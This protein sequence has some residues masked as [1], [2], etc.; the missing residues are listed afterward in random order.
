MSNQSWSRVGVATSLLGV[1][2]AFVFWRVGEPRAKNEPPA[3]TILPPAMK[4]VT[5]ES[6]S[7][8]R[9]K[10]E[11]AK[12]VRPV[13]PID[14]SSIDYVGSM[15]CRKCH[16]EIWEKY[17][18]HPM[19]NSFAKVASAGPFEDYT[20][21]AEFGPPGSRRYRVERNGDEVF[22]HEIMGDKT[23]A[24]IYDQSVPVSFVLGSGKR[25]R[26]YLIDRDGLM[27]KS[28]LSW[29]TKAHKN[30]IYTVKVAHCEPT[31]R[32]T[33][34]NPDNASKKTG[35]FW[36]NP[37]EVASHVPAVRRVRLS[38]WSAA[39]VSCRAKDGWDVFPVTIRIRF[40][41]LHRSTSPIGRN[42]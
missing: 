19:A 12:M 27:F 1:V 3:Q 22:H 5:K 23:G 18:S 16:P 36:S 8:D 20:N 26:A 42:A 21:Q 2:A 29:Y 10:T 40:P 34:F 11:S 4:L 15:A 35:W 30:V 7:A 33:T 28:S 9:L 14:P 31:G 25:G 17:Q 6:T 38:T 32:R 37:M 13:T 41:P 39:F 24:A